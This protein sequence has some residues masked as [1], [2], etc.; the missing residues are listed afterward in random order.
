MA[1]LAF[2]MLATL[3]GCRA[4]AKLDDII[5]S[6]SESNSFCAGC[7]QFSVD[8]TNNGLVDYKCLGYCAVPG[9][10]HYFVPAWV[11]TIGM[12]SSSAPTIV[13]AAAA[14]VSS[15]LRVVWI[16]SS[17]RRELLVSS[18]FYFKSIACSGKCGH[19]AGAF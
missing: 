11:S 19:M 16:V 10:Q 8:F 2:A 4:R 9:E 6:Y 13:A 3:A 15:V 5:L 18:G 12:G 7:P 17:I 14:A 1:L